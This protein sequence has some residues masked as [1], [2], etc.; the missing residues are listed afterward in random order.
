MSCVSQAAHILVVRTRCV[1]LEIGMFRC[2]PIRKV[3]YCVGW[4]KDDAGVEVVCR[5]VVAVLGYL[6]ITMEYDPGRHAKPAGIWS[7]STQDGPV[8]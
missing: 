1:M 7:K 6:H 2:D 8:A 5:L 4:W 3:D